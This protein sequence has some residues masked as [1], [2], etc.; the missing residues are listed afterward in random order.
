M[1]YIRDTNCWHK[2][3]KCTMKGTHRHVNSPLT[4]YVNIHKKKTY[5]R[6]FPISRTKKRISAGYFRFRPQFT[7]AFICLGE[8]G[9]VR[10][11]ETYSS[12]SVM[13]WFFYML[14]ILSFVCFLYI[15]YCY[16]M[17]Q[18]LIF[19]KIRTNYIPDQ[20]FSSFSLSV[21]DICLC[22]WSLYS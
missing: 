15:L 3:N 10:H 4:L 19:F 22:F 11:C 12:G 7:P 6:Y 21:H 5:Q 2:L 14:N 9:T 1:S 18:C 8:S 13:F 16:R 20:P 17:S